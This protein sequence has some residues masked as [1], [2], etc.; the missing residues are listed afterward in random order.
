MNASLD[1]A[2]LEEAD[3][4]A[5]AASAEAQPSLSPALA[6]VLA[7]AA[8]EM[9]IEGAL[10]LAEARTRRGGRSVGMRYEVTLEAITDANRKSLRWKM[11]CV[12]GLLTDGDFAT[13]KA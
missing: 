1:V 10:S 8:L 13:D 2:L 7:C 5:A 3:R 11:E 6:V 4:L 9:A 12:P